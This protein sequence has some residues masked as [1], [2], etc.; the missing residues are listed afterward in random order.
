MVELNSAEMST[1]FGIA[2]SGIVQ[3]DPLGSQRM[4]VASRPLDTLA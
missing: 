3:S 4:V 2:H 1:T